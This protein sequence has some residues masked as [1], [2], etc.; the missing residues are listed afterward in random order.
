MANR[1]R[2]PLPI[3]DPSADGL[4]AAYLHPQS[5]YT[6]LEPFVRIIRKVS[7]LVFDHSDPT[8]HRLGYEVREETP[9]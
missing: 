5:T 1:E 2:V 6:L 7:A 8:I 3:H 4:P 9:R